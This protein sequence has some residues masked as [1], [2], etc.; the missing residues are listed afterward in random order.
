MGV[1]YFINFQAIVEES[2]MGVKVMGGL[3]PFLFP[4]PL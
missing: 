2:E 1:C 4:S 3:Y